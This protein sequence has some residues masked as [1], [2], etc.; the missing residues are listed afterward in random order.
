MPVGHPTSTDESSS[1]ASGADSSTPATV[2]QRPP[3][4]TAGTEPSRR[5]AAAPSTTT[6][7]RAVAAFSQVPLAS[8]ALRVSS[9]DSWAA[10][11]ES[12]PVSAAGIRLVR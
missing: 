4:H 11:T 5:A 9:R 10:T 1:G 8:E 12:P 6:G 7:Y 3:S 2:N